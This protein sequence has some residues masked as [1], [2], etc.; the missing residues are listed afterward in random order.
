MTGWQFVLTISFH[1]ENNKCLLEHIWDD[2]ID[3]TVNN[4]SLLKIDYLHYVLSGE[5]CVVWHVMRLCQC[6]PIFK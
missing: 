4:G 3:R 2:T 1:A 6:V 5:V